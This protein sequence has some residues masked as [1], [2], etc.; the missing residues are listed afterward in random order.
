MCN[1]IPYSGPNDLINGSGIQLPSD[2]V[3]N[4]KVNSTDDINTK[5]LGL[6]GQLA[7]V[8]HVL[9]RVQVSSTYRGYILSVMQEWPDHEI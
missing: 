5:S 6:V 7:V 9:Q 1:S 4:I 2:S 8:C 3:H